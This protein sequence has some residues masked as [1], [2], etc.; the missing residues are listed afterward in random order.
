MEFLDHVGEPV[1]FASEFLARLGTA[2]SA[3]DVPALEATSGRVVWTAH[4]GYEALLFH[5]G[6][7]DLAIAARVAPLG[8]EIYWGG[9]DR[10]D[11]GDD[12]DLAN[13][14][15]TVASFG[16]ET[17]PSDWI[18]PAIEAVVREFSREFVLVATYTPR[19]SRPLKVEARLCGAPWRS[20]SPIFW[21]HGGT[22]S[23]LA[24]HAFAKRREQ[25]NVTSFLDPA[26]IRLDALRLDR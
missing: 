9:F 15:F 3:S 22:I 13:G 19:R 18:A 4:D 11:R 6:L 7:P 8:C 24:A 14:S 23:A 12:F 10:F 26:V 17:D 25:E 2:V 1:K 21:R 5:S 20:R 16:V